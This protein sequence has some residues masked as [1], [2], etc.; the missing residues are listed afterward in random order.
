MKQLIFLSICILYNI[1]DLAAQEE[2]SSNSEVNI[3]RLIH[4]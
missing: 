1:F 2:L 3:M 4:R